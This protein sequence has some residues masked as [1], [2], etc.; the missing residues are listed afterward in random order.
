MPTDNEPNSTKSSQNWPART[1][2]HSGPKYSAKREKASP[3]SP[4]TS[5]SR[6]R[7]QDMRDTDACSKEERNASLEDRV[8]ADTTTPPEHEVG[9]A[10][11][12]RNATLGSAMTPAS[13]KRAP[14]KGTG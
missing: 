3:L 7:A 6:C 10:S 5:L 1:V 8:V 12:L 14:T 13:R 9:A 4:P 2:R 11:Q